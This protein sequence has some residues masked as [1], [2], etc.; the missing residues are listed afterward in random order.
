MQLGLI[1][2]NGS[3]LDLCLWSL[4]PAKPCLNSPTNSLFTRLQTLRT[5]DRD[6]SFIFQGARSRNLRQFQD[7]SN[8][9]SQQ[10]PQTAEELRTKHRWTKLGRIKIDYI[11]VNL[12]NCNTNTATFVFPMFIVNWA[13]FH[14]R[15]FFPYWPKWPLT[16]TILV[17]QLDV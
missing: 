10:R 8:G 12:N 15:P 5:Y 9:V 14:N 13:S 6:F 4:S 17:A 16:R 11:L 2:C 7:W 1:Y 3:R